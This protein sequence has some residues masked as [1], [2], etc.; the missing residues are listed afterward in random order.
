MRKVVLLLFLVFFSVAIGYSLAKNSF[1]LK[2][3]SSSPFFPEEKRPILRFALV[4]DSHGDNANLAKALRQAQGFG[5]NFVI[6]LGDWSTV[7]TL[8]ELSVAKGIFD[9]V[10]VPYYLTAGDHDLWDS[11]NRGEDPLLNFRQVFGEPDREINQDEIQ[12]VLLDNS[13]IYMGI[14]AKSWE[15]LDNALSKGTRQ[16]GQTGKNSKFEI[17][18]SK[19]TFVIA[20]KTPFHPDSEHVMGEDS[21][22]VAKQAQSLLS[23]LVQNK[24]DG[25]FSGDLHFFAQFKD[26]SGLV[27]IT[28]VGAVT[29]ERNFQG[30]RFAIVTVFD[31]YSW[32]VEDVEIR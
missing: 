30:P 2:R 21:S 15:F 6:G 17:L 4:A 32:K 19:L 23:L 3:N 22:E 5:I 27:K 13:D 16:G 18:N 8:E 14:D 26:P 1:F 31:D 20:H 24:V 12:I 25:F 29:K 9:E 28:T 11:R 7:G 10:K